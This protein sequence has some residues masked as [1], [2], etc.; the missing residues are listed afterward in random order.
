[1]A[2]QNPLC[3]LP[4]EPSSG[5]CNPPAQPPS[6]PLVPYNPPGLSAIKYRIGTFSSFRRAMLDEVADPHLLDLLGG[7]TNP[8]ARWH[9]GMD[10]DYQAML[11]ELWAYLADILTFY[12]ERIANEAYLPTATQRDSLLW[13]TQLINYRPGPGAGASA[14]L[15]FIVEKNKLITVPASF[16]VGSKASPGKPAAVFE[17]VEAINVRGEHSAIPLSA[18]APTNQFAPLSNF[19]SFFG[20]IA[21]S[22]GILATA[23]AN[24]YGNAGAAYLQTFAL[25]PVSEEAV[26]VSAASATT[27]KTVSKVGTGLPLFAKTLEPLFIYNP[28]QNLTTRTIVLKGTNNQL[29]VGDYVLVVENEHTSGE[30]SKP[31]QITTVVSDR[32]TNTTTITWEEDPGTSYDKDAKLYALRVTAGP[33]GN[34]APDWYSL[35]PT[36][37]NQDS[38]NSTAPYANE[39]WDDS[40]TLWYYLPTPNDS[41]RQGDPPGVVFLDN[42]YAAAKSPDW[43]VL[44]TDGNVRIFHVTGARP[45]SKAA[46]AIS[47][48]VTKLTFDGVLP[49]KTFPLR[50]TTI[51]TGSELLPLQ[52]NLPL[53][54]PLTGNKL[55]LAGVY[56]NLQAGQAVIVRGNLYNPNTVPPSQIPN[57]EA[58][59]LDGPPVSD[60]VN[61]ITMVTLKKPLTNKYAR[62]STVL[63]ANVVDATQGETV[64]DEVLGS[65]DGS[66]FQSYPLKQKPLTYLPSTDPEGLA[67]VESTLTVMVNRV[68]WNEQPTLLE[69]S[70]NAQAFTTTL[71][72]SGQT[73]V[74]FGGGINAAR[75]PTGKNNI[76]ARYRKG[77]GTS[78]YVAADGIQQLIDSVPGLQKVTNPQPS[79]GGTDKESISQIRVNAPASLRTFGRAVS[80][81][82]YAGLALSYP[83]VAKASATW[84]LRDPTTL[85][86]IAQPYMQLT[87]ATADQVPLASQPTFARQLRNFLDKRRDPNVP[88]R[89]L[90]FKPVYIDVAAVIDVK[91]NY[92]RQATLAAAQAALNPG[93][94]PDNTAGYFSFERLEFGQ[95]IHLSAVYAVLQSVPGVRDVLITTLRKLPEDHDLSSVRDDIFIRPTELAVIAN[96]PADK[97]NQY[98]KVTIHLGK[99]GFVDS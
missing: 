16:R 45:A 34:V 23:A 35:P 22:P 9:E 87:V 10:G 83:G 49:A 18:V 53:P 51:L 77:L 96:D 54:D 25:N 37:N 29:A 41:P 13:L 1:M 86:A 57:A 90:D 99:G 4:A 38:R 36:L 47:A 31:R 39:K 69:S 11:I 26:I 66:A 80:A 78:G 75:P 2:I 32:T 92:P 61:N 17:T 73:M 50:N 74:V 65:S 42:V 27:S 24:L 12:Q 85:Q 68:R 98:G 62:A 63:L 71:D 46:Y 48:K 20:Q 44:K 64:R 56:T 97:S 82:D 30:K 79:L 3:V 19:G 33:F 81:A 91:D 94:N 84:L 76:H 8:F 21:I 59:I 70:A 7:V 55:V 72:D 40:N 93:L 43:V 6:A 67:A 52:N 89:I 15:A 88:L 60:P 14:S 5:C 58:G 28:F 95:S